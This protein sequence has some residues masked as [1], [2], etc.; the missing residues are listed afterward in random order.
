MI[1]I[2]IALCHAFRTNSRFSPD[3]LY[4]GALISDVSIMEAIF[5]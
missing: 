2:A 1:T 5:K 4:L 3:L